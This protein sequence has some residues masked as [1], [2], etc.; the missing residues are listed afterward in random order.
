MRADARE[1]SRGWVSVSDLAEY[2]YCPRAH[3]YRHHP[4]VG[5]PTRDSAR[6]Q[7]KGLEFHER[8]L[9]ATAARS[10]GGYG[11]PIAI[12]AGLALLGL[13]VYLAGIR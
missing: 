4:P 2:T 3:W 9:S 6:H 12:L 8:E 1:P 7:R 10:E 13:A 5:G 11:V